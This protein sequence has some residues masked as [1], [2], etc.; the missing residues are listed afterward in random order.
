MKIS[1]HSAI[2][3]TPIPFGREMNTV[4]NTR[5]HCS[6][7][8]LS[9]GGRACS[10]GFPRTGNSLDLFCTGSSDGGPCIFPWPTRQWLWVIVLWVIGVSRETGLRTHRILG[11]V[12]SRSGRDNHRWMW[13]L[14]PR[15]CAG[16]RSTERT[17]LTDGI[18]KRSSDVAPCLAS[19]KS[20]SAGLFDT[21][22]PAMPRTSMLSGLR[23]SIAVYNASLVF[24]RRDVLDTFSH[25]LPP[26]PSAYL[27][28]LA[29]CGILVS[30]PGATRY[31]FPHEHCKGRRT[32][33]RRDLAK[34][35]DMRRAPGL[36]HFVCLS[37][38]CISRIF[39]PI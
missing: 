37:P 11:L 3:V 9:R 24:S 18:C 33:D 25:L 16:S 13:V 32:W 36:M 4:E 2:H 15:S 19:Q 23:C 12:D 35:R 26:S 34:R 6:K 5:H 21:P 1:A 7:A 30:T 39:R 8:P 27:A 14:A 31:G 20:S 17:A 38:A 10:P 22:C 28:S 29:T